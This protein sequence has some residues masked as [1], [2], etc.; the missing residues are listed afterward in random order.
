MME[1][2]YSEAIKQATSR[3]MEQIYSEAIKQASSRVMEQS[4]QV[5]WISLEKVGR[6]P[7]NIQDVI[8]HEKK[9]TSK[10]HHPQPVIFNCTNFVSVGGPNRNF[11]GVQVLLLFFML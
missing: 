8:H 1:Q 10:L 2:I 9:T 11:F 7:V 4:L 3:V 5:L 6:L